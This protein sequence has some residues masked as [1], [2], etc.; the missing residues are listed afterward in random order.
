MNKPIY[1]PH[2]LQDHLGDWRVYFYSERFGLIDCYVF[3][4]QDKAIEMYKKL[5]GAKDESV[6]QGKL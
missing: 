4:S 3:E 1:L 2:I 6:Q 5:K